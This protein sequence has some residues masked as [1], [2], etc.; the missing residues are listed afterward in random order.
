MHVDLAAQILPEVSL[1]GSYR[2]AVVSKGTFP[3]P[4]LVQVLLAGILVAITPLLVPMIQ[5]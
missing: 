4:W 2:G 5:D 3:I 1:Q